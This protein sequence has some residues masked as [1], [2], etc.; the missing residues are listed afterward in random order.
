MTDPELRRAAWIATLIAVPVAV[1][2]GLALWPRDPGPPKPDASRAP[3]PT[4]SA[5]VDARELSSRAALI[6]RGLVAK[7]PERVGELPRRAVS[8]GAE[9]NAAYGH[10]LLRCGV[11][12]VTLPETSTETVYPLSKV[13]WRAVTDRDSTVWTTLDREIPVSVTVSGPPEETGQLIAALSR[14]VAET[15]TGGDPPSGCRK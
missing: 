8:A 6:C 12:P 13:C 5:S 14:Y 2:A 11:D 10:L 3:Q 15:P 7:L 1:L 4:T 9:Q